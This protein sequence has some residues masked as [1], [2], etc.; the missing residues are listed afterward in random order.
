VTLNHV[1]EKVSV[2]IRQS[3][4]V[5]GLKRVVT[6]SLSPYLTQII[7]KSGA[8]IIIAEGIDSRHRGIILFDQG[9]SSR[10]DEVKPPL[11]EQI[12]K[13]RVPVP[14]FRHMHTDI[15]YPGISAAVGLGQGLLGGEP[16]RHAWPGKSEVYVF[17]STIVSQEK[18]P[19][20]LL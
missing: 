3:I 20:R 15:T 9:C 10:T 13:H 19:R 16:A 2:I 8:D 11:V 12:V 5:S 18:A 17:W 1:K 14:E 6:I 4:V 7:L